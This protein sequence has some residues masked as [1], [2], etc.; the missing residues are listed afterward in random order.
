MSRLQTVGDYARSY[1][2]PAGSPGGLYDVAV[3]ACCWRTSTCSR[4]EAIYI[5]C[6]LIEKANV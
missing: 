5:P 6:F 2:L 1:P 4:R 3:Q